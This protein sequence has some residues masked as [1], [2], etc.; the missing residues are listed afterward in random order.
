MWRVTLNCSRSQTPWAARPPAFPQPLYF[1]ARARAR[2]APK[3]ETA[4]PSWRL[5]LPCRRTRG[6]C[7]RPNCHA[8]LMEKRRSEPQETRHRCPSPGTLSGTDAAAR[9]NRPAPSSP[10]LSSPPL[11]GARPAITWVLRRGAAAPPR[12]RSCALS[13]FGADVLRLW[14]RRHRRGASTLPPT[15]QP[16]AAASAAVT[17]LSSIGW[18]RPR[19]PLGKPVTAQYEPESGRACPSEPRGPVGNVVSGA[20]RAGLGGTSGRPGPCNTPL[21]C[22]EWILPFLF[23]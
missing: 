16:S 23:A 19:L 7:H 22:L 12:A 18:G 1:P 5:S 17:S 9:L 10:P 11:P 13:A 8:Q 15:P 20:R 2:H 3:P 21:C 6:P 14:T 4:H